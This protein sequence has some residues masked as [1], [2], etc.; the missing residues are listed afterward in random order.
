MALF[1]SISSLPVFYELY[2]GVSLSSEYSLT[3][4]LREN[5]T[6]LFTLCA[7]TLH[8]NVLLFYGPINEFTLLPVNEKISQ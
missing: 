6:L 1:W 3:I 7:I 8:M 2:S 4:I 5:L